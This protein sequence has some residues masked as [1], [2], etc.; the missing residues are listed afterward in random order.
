MHHTTQ[1][2]NFDPVALLLSQLRMNVVEIFETVSTTIVGKAF[3]EIH[4]VSP[5]HALE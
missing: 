3:I 4:S 1:A 2:Q 5:V